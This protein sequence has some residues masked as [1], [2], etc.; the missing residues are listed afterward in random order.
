MCEF[1]P[2]FWR[3][4]ASVT[5]AILTVLAVVIRHCRCFD[6]PQ[7]ATRAA[8]VSL[9][10]HRHTIAVVPTSEWRLWQAHYMAFPTDYLCTARKG[11][12]MD[13][14]WWCCTD[15]TWADHDKREVQLYPFR[16]CVWAADLSKLAGRVDRD[17]RCVPLRF[18]LCE[19]ARFEI[20]P[21]SL[22]Y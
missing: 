5:V 15:A 1:C 16:V 7:T 10:Y 19:P 21:S 12:E 3:F 17:L 4:D 18:T 14:V 11:V 6:L 2:C 20:F 13:R 22:W 9:W 8:P